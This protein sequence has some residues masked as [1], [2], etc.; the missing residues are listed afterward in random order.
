MTRSGTTLMGTVFDA[1]P[2]F[3]DVGEIRSYWRAMRDRTLCGCGARVPECEFWSQVAA[4][5]EERFGP[6]P[7]DRALALQSHVRS[8][9][10]PLLRMVLTRDSDSAAAAYARLLIQLYAA[11]GAVSGATAIVDTSKG[12]HDAYA[13]SKFT[14]LD[15]SVVHLVRDPRGVAH[16]WSR[17]KRA[18]DSV[19]GYFEPRGASAVAVRWVARNAFTEALL[20]RRLG[21]RFMRL[22]YEDFVADPN[23]AV[24]RILEASGGGSY[25]GPPVS[26]D[27]A[28]ELTGNHSVSGNPDRLRRGAI[29]I[30]LDRE[31]VEQMPT[32]PRLATTAIAAPLMRRYG[33]PIRPPR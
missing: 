14:A 26:S 9:P 21:P 3:V 19:T 32:G 12:P 30:R 16:S 29:Q 5:M 8:L 24:R 15:L 6:T 25:G 7:I 10:L 18:P 17:R 11:I 23:T 20:A 27:G 31:W 1:I 4:W 33:Y 28:I 22:R 13:L 2:G